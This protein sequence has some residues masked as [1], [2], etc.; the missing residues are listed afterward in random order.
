MIQ[1]VW[2]AKARPSAGFRALRSSFERSTVA[3]CSNFERRMRWEGFRNGLPMN[4]LEPLTDSSTHADAELPESLARLYG[5]RF[6]IAPGALYANFIVSLDGVVAVSGIQAPLVL[7]D[8]SDGDRFVMGLLRA[9]ADAVLIG[10]FRADPEHHWTPE[11]TARAP[12]CAKA[13]P[14]SSESFSRR[15]SS[16]SSFSR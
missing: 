2:K 6:G 9:R 3:R 11:Q 1:V 13:A 16:T 10:T 15:G 4:P 5:G 14:R 8:G 7:A 12:S